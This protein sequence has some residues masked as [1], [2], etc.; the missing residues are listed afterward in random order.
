MKTTVLFAFCSVIAFGQIEP[1]AGRWKPIAVASVEEYR[2]P[3]P[4]DGAASVGELAWLRTAIDE[5]SPVAAQQ[6]RYWDAGSPGYRWLQILLS[7]LGTATLGNPGNVRAL[8]LLNAAIYDATI[9]AWDSKYAYNRPRPADMDPSLTTRIPT[10]RSPSYP[11]EHAA[12][13][14]AAYTVLAYLYPTDELSYRYLAEEAGRSRLYAGVHYPSDVIAGL[15]LGRKIAA[16]VIERARMDGSDAVWT[17]SVPTGPGL[18]NGSNPV[19]PLHGSW[20]PWAL[21]SGSEFRP[22]SPIAAN[23]AEKAAELAEIKTFPRTFD[24]SQKAMY[25]QSFDGIFTYWYDLASREIFEHNLDENPPSAARI[26]ALAS[27]THYDASVACWDAKYT[28]WAIRPFQ[29]DANVVT[30]FPTPNH[31][32]YPAAHGCYSGGI[33]RTLA[34]LFPD[35]AAWLDSRADE[36]GE[37]RIWAGIHYRSDITSGL[38]LG[39]TVSRAVIERLALTDR[40]GPSNVQ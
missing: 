28:Y 7:R 39:R 4:P 24:S 16:K 40:S 21:S 25:W 1:N 8:A 13:A 36:A 9:A 19:S 15:E 23:S 10:P 17:G 26:Y 27:L 37:S 22:G 18:W 31:P 34:T 33:A 20:K 29:L 35:D 32:S 2:L 3:A 14:G 38:A 5:R 6:V 30:L 11:S 12:A